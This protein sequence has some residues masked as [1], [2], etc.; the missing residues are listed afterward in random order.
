MWHE[1]EIKESRAR[2]LEGNRSLRTP[3]L[4]LEHNI[5]IDLKEIGWEGVA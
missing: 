5:R 2:K 3:I 1:L 4:K